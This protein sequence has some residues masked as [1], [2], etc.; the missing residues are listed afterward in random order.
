MCFVFIVMGE[1]GTVCISHPDLKAGSPGP[2]LGEAEIADTAR[3][4]CSSHPS[5]PPSEA[6]V[7]CSVTATSGISF[8]KPSPEPWPCPSSAPSSAS[9][10]HPSSKAGLLRVAIVTFVST[11]LKVNHPLIC[12]HASTWGGSRKRKHPDVRLLPFSSGPWA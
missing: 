8:S 7:G 2:V 12:P 1:E 5:D 6:R 9:F 11:A 10:H 3:D 4:T